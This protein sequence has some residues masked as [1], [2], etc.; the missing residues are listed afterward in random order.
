MEF[1][2]ELERLDSLSSIH[3]T[4]DLPL[5]MRAL[6]LY[7][8]PNDYSPAEVAGELGISER[9]LRAVREWLILLGLMQTVENRSR[10]T[11]EASLYQQIHGTEPEAFLELV[12]YRLCTR[13]RLF[14]GLVNVFLA[15]RLL[16]YARPDF[17]RADAQQWFLDFN[18][19]SRSESDL[20]ECFLRFF[21]PLL[22]TGDGFGTLALLEQ[23]GAS[24]VIHPH[25]P[26][27]IVQAFLLYDQAAGRASLPLEQV[28][29][30]FNS[31]G[32]L[33]F[34][35]RPSLME[36][37]IRLQAQGVVQVD[38]TA[39]INQVALTGGRTPLRLLEEL[40]SA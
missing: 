5:S 35:D 3:V 40:T 11:A 20:R 14:S 37:L 25:V 8:D 1:T 34:L 17:A 26:H 12:Y 7:L 2:S 36:C 15:E 13:N 38:M 28:A 18:R 29:S 19:T 23:R 10:P 30:G 16:G 9:K 31:L 27:P 21:S 39:G 4:L 6:D 33:F 22:R 32:R 24:C